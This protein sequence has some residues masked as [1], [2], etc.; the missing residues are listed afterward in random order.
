MTKVGEPT[1]LISRADKPGL[2]YRPRLVRAAPTL[3]RLVGMRDNESVIPWGFW[4]GVFALAVGLGVIIYEGVSG[5]WAVWDLTWAIAAVVVG[6][7][8][9][10]VGRRTSLEPEPC[11]E[12]DLDARTLR[13][14]S[15]SEVA[16]PE[17]SLDEVTEIV[18][19]MT[20]YPVS[21][22][23]NAVKIDAFSLLVRHGDNTLLPVVEASP[24]KDALYQVARFLSQV[25]RTPLTQ[26]GL[27]VRR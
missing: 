7:I 5:L 25:T 9:M 19:G 16:L 14:T 1:A 6:V 26:V 18:Y 13:L 12:I 15:S 17:V 27:G 10:R 8:T 21:S 3:F 11:A 4:G 22:A 2:I 23:A 24:D 20:S